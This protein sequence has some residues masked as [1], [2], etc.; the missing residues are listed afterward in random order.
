MAEK[1][2]AVELAHKLRE[3]DKLDATADKRGAAVHASGEAAAT[4][5]FNALKSKHE[6]A[7]QDASAS[8]ADARVKEANAAAVSDDKGKARLKAAA[9]RHGCTCGP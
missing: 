5:A 6:I 3:A 2:Y 9:C 7:L 8:L 1:R 4:S